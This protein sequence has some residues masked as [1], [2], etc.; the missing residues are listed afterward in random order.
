MIRYNNILIRKG[1]WDMYNV[2][3]ILADIDKK[4]KLLESTRNV[5]E[6]EFKGN[7]I[8]TEFKK[9]LKRMR[10]C[11]SM[12]KHHVYKGNFD[13]AIKFDEKFNKEIRII[14]DIFV[15]WAIR[16]IMMYNYEEEE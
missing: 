2:F 15:D 4:Y 7:V 12:S 9:S 14:H 11:I 3:K 10:Y 6:H 13:T 16:R 1:I 5:L 8:P